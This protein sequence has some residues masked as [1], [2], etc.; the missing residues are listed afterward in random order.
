[1]VRVW[2]VICRVMS[3]KHQECN[4]HIH[5]ITRFILQ[6]PLEVL[7]KQVNQEQPEVRVTQVNQVILA[8]QAVKDLQ[9]KSAPQVHPEQ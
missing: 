4:V 8:I 9:V 3:A 1:M 5:F 7:G 6:V 2:G